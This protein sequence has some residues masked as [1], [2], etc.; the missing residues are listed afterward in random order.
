MKLKFLNLCPVLSLLFG[1]F[2]FASHYDMPRWDH[3]RA[4]SANSE[5]SLVPLNFVR[6]DS[7]A[8]MISKMISEARENAVISAGIPHEYSNIVKCMGECGI[9]I[10]VMKSMGWKPIHVAALYGNEGVVKWL[11]NHGE[12]INSLTNTGRSPLMIASER[13]NSKVVR[14]LVK[15]GADVNICGDNGLTS[16]MGAAFHGRFSIV[17]YLVD[18][19]AD[20]TARSE[21]GSTAPQLAA[22]NRHWEIVDFLKGLT[23]NR[24]KIFSPQ[25]ISLPVAE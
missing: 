16:L 7:D 9:D 17:K 13:G 23:L 14:F 24:G 22:L 15:N 21:D 10:N 4:E 18:N 2:S 5:Q 25:G 8:A 1:Q 11:L 3:V 12:N 19:G 6:N 20:L